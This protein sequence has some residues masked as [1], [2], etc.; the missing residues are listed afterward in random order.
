MKIPDKCPVCGS[1]LL[2]LQIPQVP[3]YNLE[4]IKSRT[5]LYVY[6]YYD[7]THYEVTVS[8]RNDSGLYIKPEHMTREVFIDTDQSSLIFYH[9]VK[10]W[11][12]N[13]TII[14]LAELV[15]LANVD[16]EPDSE[17]TFTVIGN[18][19]LK[20]FPIE[21]KYLEV[22]DPKEFKKFIKTFSN[23]MAFL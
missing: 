21:L 17:D 18:S 12:F 15:L 2:K 16:D 19:L 10:M 20:R 13:E 14:R 3:M 6:P 5:P 23:N 22:F 9:S 8:C 4:C 11:D 1:E 7:K